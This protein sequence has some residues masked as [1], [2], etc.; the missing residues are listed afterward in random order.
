MAR[1]LN[2]ALA[3]AALIS[4]DS[5]RKPNRGE[6]EATLRGLIRGLANR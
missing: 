3:E 5:P 6:M 1:L 4:V 2:A